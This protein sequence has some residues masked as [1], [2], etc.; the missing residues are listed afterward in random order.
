MGRDSILFSRQGDGCDEFIPG[1]F[2]K[3]YDNN[4][5]SV[6]TSSCDVTTHRENCFKK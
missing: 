4:I 2:L 5:Y 6:C 3:N 1:Y